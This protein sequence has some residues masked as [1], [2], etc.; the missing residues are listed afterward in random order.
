[1]KTYTIQ[2]AFNEMK[3]FNLDMKPIK[4]FLINVFYTLEG[5][6]I[7]IFLENIFCLL[8]KGEV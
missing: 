1:M 7:K 6:Q 5:Y 3:L 8:Q 4:R 2:H